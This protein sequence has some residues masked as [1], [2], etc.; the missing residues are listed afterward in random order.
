MRPA[1]SAGHSGGQGGGAQQANGLSPPARPR[2]EPTRTAMIRKIFCQRVILG[3]SSPQEAVAVTVTAG[4][5]RERKHESA[6][7]RPLFV[8]HA[9]GRNVFR[10]LFACSVGRVLPPVKTQDVG[11]HILW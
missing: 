3:L 2:A 1:E 11:S 7:N 9:T 4:M 6:R 8:S 10:F 5:Y